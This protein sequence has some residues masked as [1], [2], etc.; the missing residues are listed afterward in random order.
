MP[1]IK[2]YID[3]DEDLE[4]TLQR[5][6]FLDPA[7]L[8]YRLKNSDIDKEIVKKMLLEKNEIKQKEIF[9]PYLESY[10]KKN[11]SKMKEIKKEYQKIWDKIAEKYFELTTNTMAPFPWKFDEYLFLVS[12]F[13]SRASWG[14]RNKLAVRWSRDPKKYFFLN[15]Y[16]LVL[17]H[18][19]E[20]I[21]QIYKKRP[22]TNWYLWALAEISAYLITYKDNKVKKTLWPWLNIDPEKFS[23]PQL[24]KPIEDLE[25]VFRKNN[26]EGFT[27]EGIKYIRQYSK[28]EIKTPKKIK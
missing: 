13:Y 4:Y 5:L 12:S 2:F 18:H 28:K 9:K 19:F 14:T 26:Y 16:E 7:G 17:T 1:K 24:L 15:G 21:D 10:Y 23:Y 3:S 22:L 27:K 20:I 6:K 25:S 11:L 8:K